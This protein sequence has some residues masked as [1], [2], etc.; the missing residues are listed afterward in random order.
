MKYRS[1]AND[2][3]DDLGEDFYSAQTNKWRNYYAAV[4]C[5]FGF[6]RAETFLVEMEEEL[7]NSPKFCWEFYIGLYDDVATVSKARKGVN[8]RSLLEQLARERAERIT[9]AYRKQRS[10]IAGLK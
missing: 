10:Y 8:R 6:K 7:Y 2:A 3:D 1:S 5:G 4:F 9:R